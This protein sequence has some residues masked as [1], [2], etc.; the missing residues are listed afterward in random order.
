MG[1]VLIGA[2]R[3]D[4]IADTE[5]FERDL[6]ATRKELRDAERTMKRTATAQ[7][8]YR[9]SVDR[10]NRERRQG[11]IPAANYRRAVEMERQAYIKA[12]GAAKTYTHATTQATWA[13]RQMPAALGGIASSLSGLAAGFFSV[14]FAI[15]QFTQG[16]AEIDEIMKTARL[17]GIATNELMGLRKAAAQMAGVEAPVLDAALLRMQKRL[18]EAATGAGMAAKTLEGFG[19]DAE[20]L[21]LAGPTEA[22]IMLADEIEKIPEKGDRI[23]LMEK[24]FE[25]MG[26]KL[27]NVMEGGSEAVR[28]FIDTTKG[29]NDEAGQ[30]VEAFNDSLDDMARSWGEVRREVTAVI[31]EMSIFTDETYG[32]IP[33][34]RDAGQ[35]LS[36][37][38][39]DL[40]GVFEGTSGITKL[41]GENIGIG[42]ASASQIAGELNAQLAEATAAALAAEKARKEAGELIGG[43]STAVDAAV[44][45]SPLKDILGDAKAFGESMLPE[46]GT[47]AEYW[48]KME[49]AQLKL[50]LSQE[51]QDRAAKDARDKEMQDRFNAHM[52]QDTKLAAMRKAEAEEEARIR[53]TP[54]PD[55]STFGEG[56]RAEY[57]FLRK[58]AGASP[59]EETTEAVKEADEANAEALEKIRVI[60][61]KANVQT[62]TQTEILRGQEIKQGE[63]VTA[64]QELYDKLQPMAGV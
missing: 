43:L 52:E 49:A 47:I 25:D 26:V 19:I 57:D 59:Q 8:R 10:L 7:D 39:S 14:N 12:T 48:R 36:D 41:A 18:A 40:R 27:L 33:V 11:L 5:K 63:I 24:L 15:G 58:E 20:K 56:S 46:D 44:N 16:L 38:F 29:L 9:T 34:A 60:Q 32:L 17:M 1:E 2:M 30:N 51:A 54:P 50:Q 28:E 35:T 23:R 55:I 53:Y 45:A 3:Y 61:E 37:M 42:G 22:F 31:A 4:V 13:G 64:L 21:S 62:A 6:L